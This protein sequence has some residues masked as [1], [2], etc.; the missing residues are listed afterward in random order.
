MFEVPQAKRVKREDLFRQ[1]DDNPESSRPSSR[2]TS[3]EET[4]EV[5][6]RD[7]EVIRPDY[8]FEYD[9]ITPKSVER[10]EKVLDQGQTLDQVEHDDDDH[11]AKGEEEEPIEYQFRLFTTTSS[12]SATTNTNTN[13]KQPLTTQRAL[14]QRRPKSTVRLSVTPPPEDFIESTLSLENAGFVRPNRPDGYYFTSS[15]PTATIETSRS[16]YSQTALSDSDVLARAGSTKWP[17]TTLPWRCVH[18]TLV[19]SS[20]PKKKKEK[21][22]Q[23]SHDPNGPSSAAV[24]ITDRR[25]RLPR[26]RPSKK[27]RILNRRRLALRAELALQSQ[28]TEELERQKRTL[29]NREKKVKRKEREKLKKQ[30]QQQQQQQQQEPSQGSEEKG[31]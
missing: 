16:Q 7:E 13:T 2:S 21:S 23:I 17:G 25:S 20:D 10:E 1:D 6:R 3:P 14:Q 5:G 27:R 24:T 15:R 9:F 11:H 12:F 26:P 22:L 28:K 18:V 30:Q 19:A 8:G 31:D 4:Q 29:R